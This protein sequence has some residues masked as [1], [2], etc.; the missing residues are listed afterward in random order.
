MKIAHLID[1]SVISIN[2]GRFCGITDGSGVT[3]SGFARSVM[4]DRAI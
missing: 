1:V 4:G 3:T 2:E